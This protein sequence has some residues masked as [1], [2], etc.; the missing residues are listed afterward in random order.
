MVYFNDGS[1]I[2]QLGTADM[3]TPISYALAWLAG[4]T[5]AE[6]LDLAALGTLTFQEVDST[7]YPC[8]ALARQAL[9]SGGGMPT[10]LNAANEVA[11]DAFL[12]PRSALWILGYCC[13]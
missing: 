12:K 2:A 11:V 8:F 3:K 6:P 5:G 10:I 7:R 1:V 9:E 13:P 4:L